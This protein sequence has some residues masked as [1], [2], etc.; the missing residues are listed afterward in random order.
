[1]VE[2]AQIGCT[3]SN[4]SLRLPI[5]FNYT[6]LAVYPGALR[7]CVASS[8]SIK[9]Y[10]MRIPFP[11]THY[12]VFKPRGLTYYAELFVVDVFFSVDFDVLLSRGIPVLQQLICNLPSR[13]RILFRDSDD[14][15]AMM[16]ALATKHVTTCHGA[17][18][19]AQHFIDWRT[20][21]WA[22]FENPDPALT[23]A[24]GIHVIITIV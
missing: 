18:V 23:W 17:H 5:I 2:R 4:V 11:Y 15:N 24:Y 14:T 10:H 16:V 7:N 21:Q 8:D 13:A 1:M 22:A 9:Q 6:H 20:S 12:D 19:P 3:V